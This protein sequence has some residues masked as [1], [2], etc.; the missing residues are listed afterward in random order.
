[1]FMAQTKCSI[2]APLLLAFIK[3]NNKAISVQASYRLRG[4][5]EVEA[6]S[7]HD[8]LHMKMVRLSAYAPAAFTPRKYSWYP[9]LL[10]AEST[11]RPECG[12]ED[13]VNK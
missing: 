8:N 11:S 9:F 13:Y 5:Q 1:M 2:T 4:F 7:F 3:R 10:E 6:P 12:R